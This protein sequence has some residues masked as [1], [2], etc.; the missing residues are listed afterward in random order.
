LIKN[1]S[2]I[3]SDSSVL[4]RFNSLKSI[5]LVYNFNDT[6]DDY[7]L[8]YL[9]F[10]KLD[11]HEIKD[12]LIKSRDLYALT[13]LDY[14]LHYE[15][16]SLGIIPIIHIYYTVINNQDYFV[17]DIYIPSASRKHKK[18]MVFKG[19]LSRNLPHYGVSLALLH[20]DYNDS[21]KVKLRWFDMKFND[22]ISKTF[23]IVKHKK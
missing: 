20:K 1:V 11:K 21:I 12:R 4:E 7:Y 6:L 9:D 3:K 8:K 17:S 18:E 22:T 10:S 23:V 2:Y 16:D 19:M 13:S 14:L 15:D 5:L